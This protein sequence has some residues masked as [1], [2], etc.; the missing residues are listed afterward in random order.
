MKRHILSVLL[1]VC[2]TVSGVLGAEAPRKGTDANLYGHV[3]DR[4]THEHIP[5][6]R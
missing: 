3:V 4:E 5:Y 6:A 1:V 2:L